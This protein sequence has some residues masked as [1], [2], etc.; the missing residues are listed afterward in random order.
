M[1]HAIAAIYTNFTTEV[2]DAEGIE[3]AEGFTAGPAGDKLVLQFSKV[4]A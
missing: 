4:G 2:V 1:K 3:Q